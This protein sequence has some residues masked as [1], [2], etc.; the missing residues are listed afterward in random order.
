MSNY[1]KNRTYAII[2]VDKIT[3]LIGDVLDVARKS[4]DGQFIIWDFPKG[5]LVLNTLLADP[6]I[7]LLSHEQA[8]ALMATDAWEKKSEDLINEEKP[9]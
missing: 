8:L 4:I 3:T 7:K 5:S 6:E 1:P 9:K 2:P